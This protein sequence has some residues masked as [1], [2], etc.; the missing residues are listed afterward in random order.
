MPALTL[1]TLADPAPLRGFRHLAL[2]RR[3]GRSRRP[4]RSSVRRVRRPPRTRPPTPSS[5]NQCGRA[6]SSTTASR[7]WSWAP[8]QISGC[9]SGDYLYALGLER[10][11]GLGDLPAVRE[12]SDLISLGAQLNAEEP[13]PPPPS[14]GEALWLAS[15]TA[16]TAG[17]GSGLDE[18]KFALRAGNPGA[19]AALEAG[20]GDDRGP[21]RASPRRSLARRGQ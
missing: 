6:T 2:R 4:G 17:D 19:E 11:A 8:T 5:S 16:I 3:L 1:R 21:V 20:C 18:A 13:G 9:S 10:L 7:A 14:A 12:L 15:T